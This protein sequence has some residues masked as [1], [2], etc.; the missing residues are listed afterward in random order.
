MQIAR[1]AQAMVSVTIVLFTLASYG[2][3]TLAGLAAFFSTFPGLM[4]SPVAGAL[5]DRHGRARLVVLDYIVALALLALIGILSLMG[6]LPAWL[7][8]V[9]AAFASLTAPLSATGLRSL[10]PLIVPSHLWERINAIDSTGYIIATIFG[11]PIAGLLVSVWG[12]AVAFIVIGLCFGVAAL[13]VGRPPDPAVQTTSNGRLLNDAWQ[14]LIYTWR[15]PTL[16][17]LGVSL[18]VLN[19]VSGTLN[20]VVPLIILQR[21]GFDETVVG[22][23]IAMHGVAGIGSAFFFGRQDTRNRERTMLVVP[24]F[25][26]SIAVVLLLLKSN[27]AMLALVMIITG[28]LNGPLDIALFTVRQRRTER[29]W[30]GRAFAV[31]MSFNALGIPIG[32]AIAGVIAARS[33]EAAIALGVVTS[34]ISGVLAAV[35][36]P[37]NE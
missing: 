20:I 17:G 34:V 16:R 21:L 15:N 36:I 24:M 14:G 8:I 35:M 4:V 7:M 6:S 10:F 31:S 30:T 18:S 9:I 32:S 28:L 37:A 27:L 22:L 3:T 5:L 23:V 29:G 33:V 1:I 13:V 19:L 26:T 11:P 12:G 2:S 25:G